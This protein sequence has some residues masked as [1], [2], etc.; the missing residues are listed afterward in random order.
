MIIDDLIILGRACPE[1]L[2]DGRITVCL[3]G[4][5]P[6]HGFVRLYPTRTNMPWHRWDIVKVEVEKDERDTRAESWKIAGSRTDWEGLPNK[7]EIVGEFPKAQQ[8]NLIHNLTDDCVQDINEIRRSLGIIRPTVL[9]RY[10]DKNALY[11]QLFQPVLPG[12][13]ESTS[14]KRDFEYEPRVTYRCPICKT[15]SPHDQQILEWGFYEWVRK[16]PDNKEQ[17]WLNAQFDSEK[18]ELF[19]FVGNQYRHRT[20]FLVISVLRIPKGR[21]VQIPL[22]PF[23][24]W[25]PPEELPKEDIGG[26]AE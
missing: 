19:F 16:H 7:I 8:A 10:F 22:T 14:V 15:K 20:S 1:P 5:S 17:V 4:Y 9:N 3:G 24:K 11:G 12:L 26:E 23:I 25:T 6:T 2:K 21:A 13:G 18:H